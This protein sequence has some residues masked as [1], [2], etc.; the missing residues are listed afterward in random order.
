MRY[1]YTIFLSL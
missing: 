1:G